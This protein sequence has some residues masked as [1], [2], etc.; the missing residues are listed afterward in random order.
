MHILTLRQFINVLNAR[1]KNY[2][3]VGNLQVTHRFTKSTTQLNY[4]NYC[5]EQIL[6]DRSKRFHFLG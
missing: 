6:L 1:G 4:T 2:L 3:D 5:P